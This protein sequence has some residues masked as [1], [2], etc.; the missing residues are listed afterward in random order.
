[1]RILSR[2]SWHESV[3]HSA[4]KK[5][6]SR[7]EKVGGRAELRNRVCSWGIGEWWRFN[8]VSLNHFT[9]PV[10]L[11][12]SLASPQALSSTQPSSHTADP[13]LPHLHSQLHSSHLWQQGQASH[14]FLLQPVTAQIEI[15]SSSKILLH[16]IQCW[17]ISAKLLSFQSF[18]QCVSDAH[19]VSHV[20]QRGQIVPFDFT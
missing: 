13:L 17:N 18:S 2:S 3:Y 7:Y 14:P 9:C 19:W 11:H 5:E 16:T 8:R 12:S 4:V 20:T 6:G 15:S 10:Y 1:M